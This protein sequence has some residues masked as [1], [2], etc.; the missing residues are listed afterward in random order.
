MF[1][2]RTIITLHLSPGVLAPF[3]LINTRTTPHA[4]SAIDDFVYV[5][6]TRVPT[7]KIALD[8]VHDSANFLP[9][10]L[11]YVMC[12]CVQTLYT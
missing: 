7:Y 12:V 2:E 11:V 3:G 1:V 10:E 9:P 5:V 4:K 6:C 8:H